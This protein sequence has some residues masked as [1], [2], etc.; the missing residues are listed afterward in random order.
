MPLLMLR[1]CIYTSSNSVNIWGQTRDLNV[2][3]DQR[4]FRWLHPFYLALCWP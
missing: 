4:A 1:G 3:L 2:S